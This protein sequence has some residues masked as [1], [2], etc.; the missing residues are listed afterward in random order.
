MQT[1]TMTVVEVVSSKV[2]GFLV[3]LAV[4]YWVAPFIWGVGIKGNSAMAVTALYTAVAFIRSYVWRRLFNWIMISQH[5]VD[6][7][8]KGWHHG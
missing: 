8:E 3:A 6:A 5:E 7:I 4:T 1:K 2:V